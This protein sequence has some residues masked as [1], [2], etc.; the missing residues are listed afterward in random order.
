MIRT[1]KKCGEDKDIEEFVK[2]KRK[3]KNDYILYTCKRCNKVYNQKYFKK[4]Y[5]KNRIKLLECAKLWHQ[6]NKD[7]KKVYDEKYC[8]ENGDNKKEYDRQYRK[9]N[10]HK[11]NKRI[12]KYIK[13]RRKIDPAYK[14]RKNIS[15]SIWY[16]LKKNGSDKGRN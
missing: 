10:N 2:K 8:K 6:D 16:Y 1:C 13:N 3:N 12:S 4:Y 14:I 15:Y 7:I 9:E 5:T 11:I